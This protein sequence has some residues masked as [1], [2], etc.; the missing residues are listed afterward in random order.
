[1]ALAPGP[2]RL[3][4]AALSLSAFESQ[5]LL[6]L[7]GFAGAQLLV[8]FFS[9]LIASAYRERALLLHAVAVLLG[10]VVLLSVLVPLPARVGQWL[11]ETAMLMA[12]ALTGLVLRELVNHAGA[13]RNLRVALVV[14]SA[15]LPLFALASW[16]GGW[17]LLLPGTALFAAVVLLVILRAWPQSQPWVW[18]LTAGLLA[19]LLAAAGLGGELLGLLPRAPYLLASALTLW[20]SGVYLAT[21][22]RSRVFAETRVRVDARKV[23]DPLTG[24]STP[25]IFADRV[26]A[27]RAILRRYGHPSVLLLVEIENL[28]ALTREFGPE[29]GESAVIEAASRI[30]RSLGEADVAARISHARIAVLAEGVALAEGAANLGTR[31][32]V[33]GL[34]EP[35]PK[36]PA[37]FLQFRMV[38]AAVP[39]SGLTAKAILSRLAHRLDDQMAQASERR[40]VSVTADELQA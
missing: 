13:M 7:G 35:L 28:G 27:A 37:E 20:A 18:W 22:W 24:L 25:L 15:V 30:R 26:E 38:A 2:A 14:A 39:L 3:M 5:D 17:I 16:A 33:A 40:I 1:M 19:L 8:A 10:L 23:T 34:K 4:E 29:V 11:P 32:L 31:I 9:V 36:A 21:V 6:L 12:L